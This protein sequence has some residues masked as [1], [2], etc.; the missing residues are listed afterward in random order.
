MKWQA[1]PA[2][3][4]SVYR[5][6]SLELKETDFY[7]AGG[8][9]LAFQL[10]HRIS[11]DLDFMSPSFEAPEDLLSILNDCRLEFTT[12]LISTG[13]LY[14]DVA[15][16]QASFFAYRYPLLAPLI[17]PGDDL[18]PMAH[19]DDIVAMKLA[20]IS[21]RGS[22]KDFI[23]LWFLVREG[24]AMDLCLELYRQKYESRDIGHVIRSLSYFEDADLEPQPRMLINVSWEEIRR[25]LMSWIDQLLA[26]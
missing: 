2:E 14:L 9:A 18:L 10:G 6:L 17:H 24:Y 15:G 16:V 4:L 3:L 7:L 23:D 5:A 20:A 12:T 1:V 21:S 8:T 22:R 25:D 13:T 19:P 26:D 11:V